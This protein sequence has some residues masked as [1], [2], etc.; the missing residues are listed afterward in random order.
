[1]G[2]GDPPIDVGDCEGF[3]SAIRPTDFQSFHLSSLSQSEVKDW[4]MID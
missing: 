4:L 3:R 2:D 1:M